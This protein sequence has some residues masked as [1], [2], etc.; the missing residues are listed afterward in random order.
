[1]PEEWTRDEL[2]QR[3]RG[4]LA[5]HAEPQLGEVL[6]R[7]P[8]S[9]SVYFSYYDVERHD[10]ALAKQVLERPQTSLYAAELALA[11]IVAG[12][13]RRPRGECSI[14]FRVR[15]L[16]KSREVAV[17]IRD[18][19]AKHLGKFVAI[20]C[21]VKRV[22]DVRP[23]LQEAMFQCDRCHAVVQEPQDGRLLQEPV[24]CYEDQSGCGRASAS[25]RFK[26]LEERSQVVDFQRLEVQEPPEHSVSGSPPLRFNGD[27]LDDI[28]GKV[29]PGERIFLNGILRAA[30][31]GEGLRKRSVLDIYLEVVS[32]DATREEEE[33]PLTAAE[34][35]EIENLAKK[36]GIIDRLW[37]S[38]APTLFELNVE[39]LGIAL[40]L[41]GGVPKRM[42]DS[43]NIR[44]DIHILLLGDP[45]TG[46][47]QL[48]NFVREIAPRVIFASGKGAS[49]AGLTA[50]VVKDED[51]EGRF[52]LEAGA[53]VLAN[54]GI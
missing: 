1:M 5:I 12:D 52:S 38:I 49:A 24:Q 6:H 45:S 16:P 43:T 18:L 2:M 25:T 14:H 46:K 13:H 35:D 44:G 39:K 9:K 32:V 11:A 41:F 50:A 30:P 8:E 20:P 21:L 33:F 27:V 7:Y 10:E 4:F 54:G 29:L 42:Q 31:K 23:K 40:A 36:P 53:L 47:S 34:V 3:W 15:G 51:S 48:L 22:T 37:R 19:R 26:L 17:E 28:T